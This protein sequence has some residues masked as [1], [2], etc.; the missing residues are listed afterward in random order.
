MADNLP[1]PERSLNGQAVLEEDEYTAA[2]SHIIARDFFPSLVHL[3]AA[4]QYL[5]ALKT[6]DSSL[7]NQSVRRLEQ[8]SSTPA[9]PR[10]A[11]TPSQT[12]YGL[13][14]ETP[15]RTPRTL[16]D[17]PP[18]KRARY[19]L[20]ISLDTF[21]ARYTSEDN[22]SFTKILD[23]ENRK[24][25]DRWAWAWEA[26]QRVEGQKAKAIEGRERMLIE[27]PSATGV[28]ER[29]MIDAPKPAGLITEGET[30]DGESSE[31]RNEESEK[32]KGKGKELVLQSEDDQPVDVMAPKKDTRPAGVDGWRFK[33]RN[34]LMFPPDANESPYHPSTSAIA[35]PNPKVV[36][37]SNTRLPEQEESTNFSRSS[38]AP[39]SPTRSRI[40][41]AISGTPYRPRSPPGT[42]SLVPDLPSPTP[43]E[44]GPKAV[45][46]L[47]TWGTL[48]GT[49]RVISSGDDIPTPSTP[50][51]IAAPSSRE[52]LSHRL[53]NDASRRLRAKADLI[54]G[55][56]TPSHPSGKKPMSALGATVRK[57]VMPPPSWTPQRNVAATP[58]SLTPAAKRLLDRTTMGTAATRRAEAMARS[59][60]WEDRRPEKE[61]LDKV[62]W[63]PTPSPV[64]R[65]VL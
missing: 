25:R 62:R 47:M 54:N 39:P 30:E 8:L 6:E 16:G 63:T 60:G 40:D 9:L 51:R 48:M 44:L 23:D 17:E 65:R 15:L 4:H 41:A 45:K 58:G 52:S 18:S 34:S 26:Q 3:D 43:S 28:R 61:E 53:S 10:N 32:E 5:D 35:T 37:H 36:L 2:L 11:A 22:S 1:T 59:A 64:T 57:G 29:F 31:E 50:F 19:D 27:G 38:S 42:F 46:Q 33:A 21:Q 7:I 14:G 56:R 55:G 20:D 13:G 24:R 12:P 49:P